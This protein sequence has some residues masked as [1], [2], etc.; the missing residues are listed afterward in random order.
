MRKAYEEAGWAVAHPC[1]MQ[2]REA[3]RLGQRD[4][5]S[6]VDDGLMDKVPIYNFVIGVRGRILPTA[7]NLLSLSATDRFLE[8]GRL[9]E[10]GAT[11]YRSPPSRPLSM[12][13]YEWVSKTVSTVGGELAI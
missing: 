11:S 10:V 6:L 12:V 2:L 1:H 9:P 7:Q 3:R 13:T 8:S 5:S 4:L